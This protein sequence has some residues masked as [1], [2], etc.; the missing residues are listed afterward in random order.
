VTT[1][2]RLQALRG[3]HPPTPTYLP[4]SWARRFSSAGRSRRR[5]KKTT[6]FRTCTLL[7]IAVGSS[8]F[9]SVRSTRVSF[10]SLLCFS[11]YQHHAKKSNIHPGS[12][13]G[14]FTNR[15]SL[16]SL[17]SCMCSLYFP[18]TGRDVFFFPA[19]RPSFFI[20]HPKRFQRLT[21]RPALL[22]LMGVGRL[23]LFCPDFRK[24]GMT[25]SLYKGERAGK[26]RPFCVSLPYPEKMMDTSFAN[27]S[28]LMSSK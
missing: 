16:F 28:N 19:A 3:S 7:R 22:F 14:F 11:G 18:L 13:Q 15:F 12:Q 1:Y 5:S 27:R 6:P 17:F 2:F 26:K 9:Y 4:D 21:R 24:S 23:A 8:F 20:S 25:H 10:I